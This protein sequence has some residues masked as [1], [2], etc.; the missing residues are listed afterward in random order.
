MQQDG[1]AIRGLMLLSPLSG[2]L[3]LGPVEFVE[4]AQRLLDVGAA[5]GTAGRALRPTGEVD[6]VDSRG[7]APHQLRRAD[8]RHA[9]RP[10]V[11]GNPLDELS[12]DHRADP[13]GERTERSGNAERQ[14]LARELLEDRNLAHPAP[15]ILGRCLAVGKKNGPIS[16]QLGG[17]R[18]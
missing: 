2:G 1:R 7:D 13:L 18:G 15:T 8:A 14:L 16:A 5:R 11:H 4:G 3:R 6:A 9:A 12:D 10:K 17:I